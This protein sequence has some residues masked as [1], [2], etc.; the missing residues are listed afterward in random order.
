MGGLL[1]LYMALTH[2]SDVRGLSFST[3]KICCDR[4]VVFVFCKWD[5]CKLEGEGERMLVALLSRSVGGMAPK[6]VLG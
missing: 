3:G 2:A 4:T 5:C 6:S 1:V